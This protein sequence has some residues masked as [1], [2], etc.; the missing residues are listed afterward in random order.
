MPSLAGLRFRP[1]VCSRPS[2]QQALYT[3]RSENPLVESLH[4]NLLFRWFLDLNL[5]DE[6]WDNRPFSK[7]QERL[8]QHKVAELFFWLC[9]G[10]GPSK[11]LGQR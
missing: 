9:G 4:Y 5:T 11:W 3:I 1:S 6:L 8:L 2:H 10:I 7:N